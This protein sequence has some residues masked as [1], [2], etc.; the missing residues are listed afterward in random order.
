MTLLIIVAVFSVASAITGIQ[1]FHMD[2]R[3]GTTIWYWHGYERLYALASAVFFAVAFY[4]VYR[5]LPIA[6]QLGRV[7]IYLSAA[8][9]ASEVWRSLGT[10]ERATGSSADEAEQ[11]YAR[12]FPAYPGWKAA[13]R[14]D[15]LARQ[16]RLYQFTVTTVKILD[17][18]NLGDATFVCASVAER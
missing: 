13:L 1:S 9:F 16:Y 4:A 3:I 5:R 14:D 6:W 10:C 8:Y 7:F 17:E 18:K 12:R 11:C 15:D 2:S